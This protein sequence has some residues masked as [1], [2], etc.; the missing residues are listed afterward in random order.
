MD[1]KHCLRGL[2]SLKGGGYW[3][4]SYTM[5]RI[6]VSIAVDTID[7]TVHDGFKGSLAR[8][9]QG[10]EHTGVQKRVLASLKTT[11]PWLL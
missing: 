11:E 5:P 9:W 2:R 1:P 7:V 10:T 8:L 4:D 3:L 6:K